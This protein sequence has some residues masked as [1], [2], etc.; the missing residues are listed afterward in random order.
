MFSDDES[1]EKYR[2]VQM[3]PRY[4]VGSAVS[5]QRYNKKNGQSYSPTKYKNIYML[6]SRDNHKIIMK[7]NSVMCIHINQIISFLKVSRIPVS[8]VDRKCFPV[9]ITCANIVFSNAHSSVCCKF[10]FPTPTQSSAGFRAERTVPTCGSM[11][12][13]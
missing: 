9:T 3:I 12:L 1:I 5:L 10:Y 13:M 8:K 7:I 11:V 4:D 2:K 6:K